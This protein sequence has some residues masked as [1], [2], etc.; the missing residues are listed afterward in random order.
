MAND[1]SQHMIGWETGVACDAVITVG[2]A[3][4][5]CA[6]AIQ[7]KDY[8]GND[9]AVPGTV[10]LYFT[11][12]ADGQVMADVTD[13]AAGTDGDLLE[14]LTDYC[15]MAVSEADGD[16][17]VTLDGSGADTV[18]LNVRLPN[19]KVVISSVITFTS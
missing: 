13:C 14:L 16:I 3:S 10:D 17:D 2:T 12:D 11:S 19:G 1:R 4:D 6:V 9:L 18:Y 5:T 15:F 8:A 7:L